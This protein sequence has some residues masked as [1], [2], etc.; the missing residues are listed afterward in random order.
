VIQLWNINEMLIPLSVY[1]PFAGGKGNLVKIRPS[2]TEITKWKGQIFKFW[3]LFFNLF[4][5]ANNFVESPNL[6]AR[7][8]GGPFSLRPI[9][10]S[11]FCALFQ[12]LNEIGKSKEIEK[13]VHNIPDDLSDPFWHYVL[14]DPIGE[15]MN[16]SESFA[17]D[18]LFY[19]LNL[20]LKPVRLKTLTKQY[21]THKKDTSV[22]LPDKI[23]KDNSLF[24]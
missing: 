15:K 12:K 10:Q 24:N 4:P 13:Y 8:N 2:E 5:N 18:Y 19:M 16:G 22:Q 21:Q 7:E 1:P 17:R 14:Y 6:L 20:P 9:G 23:F 11:I 3:D